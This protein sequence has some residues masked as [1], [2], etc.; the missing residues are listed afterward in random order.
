MSTNAESRPTYTFDIEYSRAAFSISPRCRPFSK[1]PSFYNTT[2]S[3]RVP[4]TPGTYKQYS[5]SDYPPGQLSSMQSI[6]NRKPDHYYEVSFR[7]CLPTADQHPQ[8]STAV[9]SRPSYQTAMNGTIAPTYPVPMPTSSHQYGPGSAPVLPPIQTQEHS[10]SECD[11]QIRSKHPPTP[12]QLKHD[13]VGGVAAHLDY[14]V[15]EMIDFVSEM[16]H[17]MYD[18]FAS[19]ICL[20]DID[21]TRSVLNSKFSPQR[22]FR[23]YVSQVLSSTRLPSSTVLFGLL[24]LSKRMTLLSNKGRYNQNARDVYSMLTTALMLGSKFLDDNT[25]QNRSWSEVSNIPVS[26]LNTLEI[27][28]LIDIKWDMH[29]DQEDPQGFQLWLKHWE[30]YQ[31]RKVDLSLAESMRQ[32]HIEGSGKQRPQYRAVPEL[33][34]LNS[35]YLYSRSERSSIVGFASQPQ[36]PWNTPHHLQWQIPRSQ[37]DYSPPSAPP[38][39]PTTPDAYGLLNAYSYALQ[40]VQPP[41]KLPP[42]LPVLSSNATHS[43]YPTPYVPSYSHYSHTNYCDCSFC[44]PHHEHYFLA[45]DYGPQP[46]AA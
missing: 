32:T 2:L 13:K 17:G 25:F 5:D 35:Q 26:D 22:E 4:P 41:F 1:M 23:K 18:I 11:R 20:A 10:L 34:P 36:G 9:P 16:A 29:I 27:E 31:A 40:P 43:G 6:K 45:S 19:K 38:T 42:T 21:M 44:N 33:P 39:G 46:V 30:R 8:Y 24:Y 15:D 7:E 28:W 14:E 37:T 3:H 12:P